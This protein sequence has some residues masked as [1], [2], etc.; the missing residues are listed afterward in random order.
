MAKQIQH[1]TLAGN[2]TT[3]EIIAPIPDSTFRGGNVVLLA[4]DT[5][6]GGKCSGAADLNVLRGPQPAAKWHFL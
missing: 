6:I 4:G 3:T 2:K 1:A 5:A